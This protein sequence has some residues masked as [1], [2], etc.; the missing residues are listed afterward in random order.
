MEGKAKFC[1]PMT[2]NLWYVNQMGVWQAHGGS[3]WNLSIVLLIYETPIYLGESLK[4][5]RIM[6]SERER[7]REK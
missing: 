6:E 3:G 7:E 1:K 5:S 4:I 2:K